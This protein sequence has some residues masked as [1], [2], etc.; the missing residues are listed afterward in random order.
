MYLSIIEKIR[1][2]F[3]NAIVFYRH[4]TDYKN[5]HNFEVH[6]VI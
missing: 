5:K 3:D 4:P 2:I 1:V 6:I